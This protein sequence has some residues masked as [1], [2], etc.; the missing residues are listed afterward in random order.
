MDP[1]PCSLSDTGAGIGS[2]T[3]LDD[4]ITD[5]EDA[6]VSFFLEEASIGRPRGE[7]ACALIRE[8]NPDV[9]GQ[10]VHHVPIY[11]V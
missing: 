3:I 8:M 5:G 10:Y 7:E 1:P 9:D 11:N 2:F 4:K 6:G